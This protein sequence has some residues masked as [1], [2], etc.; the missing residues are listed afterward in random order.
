MLL[1]ISYTRFSSSPKIKCNA[2][3]A[4]T[5]IT[6]SNLPVTTSPP[7]LDERTEQKKVKI[8]NLNSR[9]FFPCHNFHVY[10]VSIIPCRPKYNQ[11][12]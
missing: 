1:L 3:R 10:Y 9:K 6:P 11:K 5:T 2:Q 4:K 7:L 8:S 12:I